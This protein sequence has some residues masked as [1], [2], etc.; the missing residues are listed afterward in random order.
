MDKP[1]PDGDTNFAVAGIDV[2]AES[3]MAEFNVSRDTAVVA[4]TKTFECMMKYGE[5]QEKA[6]AAFIKIAHED[7]ADNKPWAIEYVSAFYRKM[8]PSWTEAYDRAVANRQDPAT[9]IALTLGFNMDM[10]VPAAASVKHM[11]DGGS[12]EQMVQIMSLGAQGL[13]PE[14]IEARI[15]S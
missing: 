15:K 1:L 5:S 12:I 8:L 2:V 10:A 6:Q 13:T 3:M 4:V 11:K 9:V 7:M 14:E